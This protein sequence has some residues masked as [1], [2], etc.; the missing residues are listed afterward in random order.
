[1]YCDSRQPLVAIH[2]YIIALL[3]N[4]TNTV[5]KS[6]DAFDLYSHCNLRVVKLN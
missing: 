3:S 2:L 1:M 4:T 6:V 5:Y